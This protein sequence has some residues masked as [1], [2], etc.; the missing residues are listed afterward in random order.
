MFD[1]KKLAAIAAME[2]QTKTFTDLSDEVW[3]YA[4]L[5]LYEHKSCAAFVR[6]LTAAGFQVESPYCGLDTAFLASYGSGKPVIAFLA[7]YDALSGLSQEGCKTEYAPIEGSNNGHGCGHNLLG[8][9]SFAAAYAVKKYLEATGKEGTVLLYGCPGE[10]GGASKTWYAKQGGF[11]GVDIALCWHP[12]DCFEVV[13]G[14]SHSCIQTEYRFKGIAAQPTI[15]PEQGRSALDAVELMNVGI[16]FLREHMAGSARIHY[17][18]TD[19]GGPSPNVVQPHARVLY[20][21]RDISVKN[22][23]ALQKRVDAI[24]EGAAMMT[25]TTV[26]KVFI[27]GLANLVPNKTLEDLLYETYQNIE[28]PTFTAEE[29]QYF[30]DLMATYEPKGVAGIGAQEDAEIEEWVQEQTDYGKKAICNF[31]MPRKFTMKLQPGSTDV[32]DVSWLVPTAQV[33]A[34]STP[35]NCPGHTWQKVTACKSTVAHKGMM[36]A[37]K[38][39]ALAA[40]QLLNDP[41]KIAAAKAEHAKRTKEGYVCPIPDGET[42]K[43]VEVL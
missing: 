9:G 38:V 3:E 5:S 34:I 25:E 6:E 37:A 21:V 24:A 8:A 26:E 39:L 14:T 11:D 40:M 2:E 41:E 33:H 20:M 27:D 36:T 42:I 43:P 7:E 32:G 15:Y 35:N 28:L 30:A 16:Q 4:E 10:E 17:A 19:A 13:S 31:L 22:T 1:E 23:V 12:D 18:I 29:E